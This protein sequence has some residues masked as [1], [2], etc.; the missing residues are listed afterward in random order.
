MPR[1]KPRSGRGGRA[2]GTN[3]LVRFLTADEPAQ[4]RRARKIMEAG[5]VFLSKTVLLETEWV[6]RRAYGL[7]TADILRAFESLALAAEVEIENTD[8]VQRTLPW[9]RGGMGFADA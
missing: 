8:A 7:A 3:V 2:G 1:S 5:A 6:L 4:F 9:F